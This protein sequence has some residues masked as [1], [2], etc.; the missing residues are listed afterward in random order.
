M[1]TLYKTYI[2]IV[3]VKGISIIY[4][5]LIMK[6]KLMVMLICSVM[7]ISP[8]SSVNCYASDDVGYFTTCMKEKYVKSS[9]KVNK[10]GYTM[11]IKARFKQRDTITGNVSAYKLSNA[12]FGGETNIGVSSKAIGVHKNIYYF[13]SVG[14]ISG[15]DTVTHELEDYTT[16]KSEMYKR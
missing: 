13:K 2:I 6:K 3:T 8:L 7:A 12:S 5:G 15:C 4:G 9:L 11:S 16:I 14:K 10:K 1:T